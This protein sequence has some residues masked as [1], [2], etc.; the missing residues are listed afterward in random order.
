MKT[1]PPPKIAIGDVVMHIP[2]DKCNLNIN[3]ALDMDYEK[4]F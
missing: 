4:D 3:M 2:I 1:L